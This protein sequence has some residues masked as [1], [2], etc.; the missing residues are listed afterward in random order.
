MNKEFIESLKSRIS[1]VDIISSR[2]RL[3]RSGNAW[4]GL[5]PFHK[6]KTGSFKVDEVKGFFYCFGCG[7]GGDAIKFIMEYD[8]TSFQ[9]AIETIAHQ[10][11][12]E[13]PSRKEN[14]VNDSHYSLREILDISKSYFTESL[15]SAAGEKARDYLKYRRISDDSVSK[16]Q[17]G[18][19]PNNS[20][21]YNLLKKKGYSNHDIIRTGIFFKSS[22]GSDL[23]NRY[24]DRL[25]FPI[26]D[27]FGK[28]VGF[29]GR[30][31]NKSDKAKYINSP[32]TEI[33]K[34]S[35]H[36]YGYHLAKKGSTRRIIITEGYLDVISLHQAEFDGAVAPLGTTISDTQIEMCWKICS[37]PVISLDGDQA[38][39]KASYRWTDKILS[40]AKPGKS[41]KFAILPQGSDPDV[42]VFNGQMDVIKESINNA[43]PLSQWLWEG[44]FRLFPSQTPEQKAELIQTLLQKIEVIQDP[45]LK[46][47]Y[48]QYIKRR[49]YSLGKN[50]K[51]E[52]HFV[53]L[54]RA[55][56]AKEKIE[57]I[58]LVT[59]IN[60]PYIMDRVVESFV[61]LEFSNERMQVIKNRI[62][63]SY[64]DYGVENGEKFASEIGQL[65][66]D[67]FDEFTDIK[68]EA[69]FSNP[70]ASEEDALSGWNHLI[71]KYLTDPRVQEDL[72]N[73]S[74]R[75]KYSFSE[76]DWQRLKALKTE[77]IFDKTKGQEL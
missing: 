72:Q 58:L 77:I 64:E 31:L 46:K 42:L 54:R 44:A 67:Q 24:H 69:A 20:D 76:D 5:C 48:S 14:N 2:I 4:F 18:Y 28:C 6:E 41:F 51:T 71:K 61:K 40:C 49:E 33:Y 66:H 65:L 56:T 32:E 35:E 57:K 37:D 13:L 22:R 11:G 75:L 19:A 10:Y 17:I 26:I 36:L 70:E 12:I 7:A 43:I 73:A 29:G 39:L 38:G 23:I 25:I 52:Q 55:F 9:E 68:F 16:F 34:K 59:L 3:K 74:A 62:I 1:I 8:K 30:I 45:S 15:K 27:A 21:L 47:L 60:H 53:N 50:Q 63:Q